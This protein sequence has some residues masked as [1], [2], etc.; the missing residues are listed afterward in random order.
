MGIGTLRLM[1]TDAINRRVIEIRQLQEDFFNAEFRT[2]DE[3]WG[4][5]DSELA[6]IE[7]E[8]ASREGQEYPHPIVW[9]GGK[10][11]G[12]GDPV[13]L[14]KDTNSL[15]LYRVGHAQVTSIVFR[16]V[17]LSRTMSLSERDITGHQLFPRGL[18]VYGAYE[19]RNSTWVPQ[20][21]ASSLLEYDL[22]THRITPRQL[23]HYMYCFKDDTIE[24]ISSEPTIGYVGRNTIEVLSQHFSQSL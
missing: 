14:V 16:L 23:K 11:I 9:P 12:T 21:R 6:D 2:G 7:R 19:I 4:R 10:W 15:L 8:L 20:V 18:R 13:L 17:F 1:S 5:L 3:A 24:I 22:K